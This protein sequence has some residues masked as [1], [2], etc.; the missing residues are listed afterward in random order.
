[1]E[2]SSLFVC[3]VFGASD[4]VVRFNLEG[5]WAYLRPLFLLDRFL[6]T[7]WLEGLASHNAVIFR[8][9]KTPK[10]ICILHHHA[11]LNQH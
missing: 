7:C 4:V 2:L 11:E 8:L 9:A 1:M 10:A 3:L 5:D 6:I